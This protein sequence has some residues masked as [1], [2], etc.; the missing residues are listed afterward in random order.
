MKDHINANCN[1]S[2]VFIFRL[3]YRYHYALYECFLTKLISSYLYQYSR[4]SIVNIN[5]FRYQNHTDWFWMPKI[6]TLSLH[7]G[8]R[9]YATRSRLSEFLSPSC[10]YWRTFQQYSNYYHWM[11]FL[12][13]CADIFL[14]SKTSPGTSS[15]SFWGT[16]CK[17]RLKRWKLRQEVES[18]GD[19]F[20]RI[21]FGFINLDVQSTKRTKLRKYVA[22][23]GAP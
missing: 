22:P 13:N 19:I 12:T 6:P 14:F 11:F 18:R 20:C 5:I 7:P 2:T 1:T 15:Q 21:K 10:I 17:Y 9:Y 16:W 4:Q 8:S 3:Y 23:I